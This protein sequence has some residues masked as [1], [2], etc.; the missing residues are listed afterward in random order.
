MEKTLR[1]SFLDISKKYLFYQ[2]AFLFILSIELILILFFFSFLIDSFFL[3]LSL[4]LVFFTALLYFILRLYVNEQKPEEFL[5]LIDSLFLEKE[6][7]FYPIQLSNSLKTHALFKNDLFLFKELL[8]IKAIQLH[9]SKVEEEP[10]VPSHHYMLG[11][12]FVHLG[13]LYLKRGSKQC[14]KKGKKVLKQA[15]K[16]LSLVDELLPEKIQVLEQLVRAHELLGTLQDAIPLYE[17]LESLQPEKSDFTYKLAVSSF[18]LGLQQ[19]G[20]EAYKRLQEKDPEKAM[21]SIAY[22]GQFFTDICTSLQDS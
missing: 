11:V 17:K 18:K 22:Y 9:F 14:E 7:P 3:G 8:S 19:K 4:A 10:L 21:K 6:D 1:T 13:E 16:E 20:L 15:V 5:S 2:G 12:F